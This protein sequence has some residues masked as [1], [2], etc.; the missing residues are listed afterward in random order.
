MNQRSKT[1]D[2]WNTNTR[3]DENDIWN[4]VLL[5]K[6]SPVNESSTGFNLAGSD[7][8][9]STSSIISFIVR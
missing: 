7:V 5:C 6:P 1:G 8:W 2:T 4:R 3:S 9:P